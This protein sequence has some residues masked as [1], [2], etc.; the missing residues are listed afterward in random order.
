VEDVLFKVINRKLHLQTFV[1]DYLHITGLCN[2]CQLII[3]LGHYICRPRDTPFE[4]GTFKL[5]M[6]FSEEYPNKPPSVRFV[7]TMFHPNGLILS[8]LSF[9]FSSAYYFL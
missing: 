4:D 6:E 3:T 9:I 8:L 5:T 7:S 2:Y 1:H